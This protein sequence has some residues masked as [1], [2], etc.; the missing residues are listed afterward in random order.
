MQT[1]GTTAQIVGLA[2]SLALVTVVAVVG[3]SWTDTGAGSWYDELDKPPWT[4]PGWAFGVVWTALYAAMAV[5]AWLVW[6]HTDRPRARHQ[7]LGAYLVQLALNL[8]WTGVFFG[9]EAPGWAT[10]EIV[11]LAVV[12]ALT[13]RWFWPLHRIAAYLLVPYLGWVVFAASLSAGV[14]VLN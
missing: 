6:R 14:F 11:V 4:P 13:T 12:L 1:R 10:L 7:A 8:G 2:V 5:A 9:L 3:A